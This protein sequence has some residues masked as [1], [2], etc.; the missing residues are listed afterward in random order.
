MG[1]SKAEEGMEVASPCYIAP[2]PHS[3]TPTGSVLIEQSIGEARQG[4]K[5]LKL[6]KVARAPGDGFIGQN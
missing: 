5:P 3:C 4:L 1:S 6:D 2:V